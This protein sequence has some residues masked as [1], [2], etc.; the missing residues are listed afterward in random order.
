[1]S[2]SSKS[3]SDSEM[4]SDYDDQDEEQELE[5][6][7]RM[8]IH[9]LQEQI[10]LYPYHY[11]SHQKLIHTIRQLGE[12]QLL[13]TVRQ[14]M[15]G[16][17]PM[18]IDLWQQW[19]LD[20][21]LLQ[22]DCSISL[23]Q[24]HKD[25]LS[26]YYSTELWFDRLSLTKKLFEDNK[27]PKDS[28]L[29]EFSVSSK[30]IGRD[31]REGF[32][33]WK[34]YLEV[35]ED[36]GDESERIELVFR[37]IFQLPIIGLEDLVHLFESFYSPDNTSEAVN[38]TLDQ[39]QNQL[40]ETV[41]L[42]N[43]I[44]KFEQRIHSNAQQINIWIEYLLF[45]LS[46]HTYQSRHWDN[47][48]IETVFERCL[49]I[50]FSNEQLWILY[51]SFSPQ[52]SKKALSNIPWSIKLAC[53]YLD[54]LPSP[55]ITSSFLG[56]ASSLNSIHAS[57]ALSIEACLIL[58][59][60]STPTDDLQP[61][62]DHI[63]SILK[64]TDPSP[65]NLQQLSKLCRQ[66]GHS[67]VLWYSHSHLEMEYLKFMAESSSLEQ[68]KGVFE[69]VVELKG[70]HC[71]EAACLWVVA[72]ERNGSVSSL[73]KARLY[74]EMLYMASSLS[75]KPS[76]SDTKHI[77]K[78]KKKSMPK[79]KTKAT[80]RANPKRKEQSLSST[81]SETKEFIE[82]SSG[83]SDAKNKRTKRVK[84]TYSDE[85][86]VFM[87]NVPLEVEDQ[88]IKKLFTN[89]DIGVH[90]IRILKNSLGRSKGLVYVDLCQE[91]D[92]SKAVEQMNGMKYKGSTLKVKKSQPPSGSSCTFLVDN[93]NKTITKSQLSEALALL[94][95]DCGSISN[96]RIPQNKFD[97]RLKGCAYID[98]QG[99]T[100]SELIMGKTGTVLFGKSIQISNNSQPTKTADNTAVDTPAKLSNQDFR[101]LFSKPKS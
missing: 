76:K 55:S 65:Y 75:E 85:K 50:H 52:V 3:V 83:N 30:S 74:R 97:H 73:S 80:P 84:E 60:R 88:D 18:G 25:A 68:R 36:V 34:L 98:F 27:I 49:S 100:N 91:N 101:N 69:K 78:S 95:A 1:M 67:S 56:I 62:I 48:F 99:D 42:R 94:F 4:E 10:K 31:F 17:L 53:L 61:P 43:S 77:T 12:P 93:L 64:Y 16:L 2:Q 40:S 59:R 24:L 46:S 70:P 33:F 58:L 66:L 39:F 41:S 6:Q 21:S 72:E 63:S 79:A 45:I 8:E 7:L 92:I 96:I 89:H 14:N 20:H 29:E 13:E 86:T 71:L 32:V 28:L 26:D 90:A 9:S 47:H 54:T 22:G 37:E 35:L 23:L 82:D 57:L 44:L 38:N 87:L 19:I 11:A 15:H 81:K 5:K 51:A